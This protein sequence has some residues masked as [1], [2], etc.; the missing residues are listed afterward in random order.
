MNREQQLVSECARLWAPP[1]KQK[2]SEWAEQNFVLS[3][4]YSAHSGPLKLY[5]FQRE[6]L[7][8]FTDPYVRQLVCDTSTQMIKTLLQQIAIAYVIA[9]APGP[10]LAAQPT[11]TDAETFSKERLAPMIR[12]MA[13][14][15]DR[16]APERKTSKANTT[17]HKVFPGGSLSLI[18]AQTPGDFARRSIRY[19]FADERDKW[20]TNVGKEGD[21]FSLGVK[22]TATF[23]SLAKIIQTC[24]PTIE[25]QSQIAAAYSD[26][27]QRKFWV[28]CPE[29]GELQI[30][31]WE[32]VKFDV[33]NPMGTARYECHQCKRGISDVERWDRCESGVW[34]PDAHFA[35]TAGFWIS[36]LYSP[37]KRLGELATDFLAKKN[38]PAELQ[39]F[40]NT[41][42]AETWKEQGDAPDWEKLMART[43]PRDGE[44]GYR[45]GEVPPGVLFLTSGVD[46]QKT[47][48]QGHVWGWGRNR[49]RW[50][51]DRFILEGDPYRDLVWDALAYQ[52]N[53]T[54]RHPSGTDLSIV[55]MAVDSGYATQEVY[56]WARQQGSA[57]VMVIKGS[58]HGA[59][60]VSTPSQVDITI[61]GKKIKH[62]A[63]VYSVNVSMCKSEWYGLL[64]K[65]RPE[66]GEPYPPGWVHFA[67]DLDEEFF[68]Q[69]TAEQL[70]T[71]IVKGYRKSE[72]IKTRERNEDLD[73]AASYAR[74][75]ASVLGA[76][77]VHDSHWAI[78]PASAPVS[79]PPQPI[80]QQAPPPQSI[81][82]RDSRNDWFS[83]GRSW[84]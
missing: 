28:P 5:K 33:T 75:A 71:H 19:F 81:A 53:R 42:L 63:R 2:L 48:L 79:A 39:T 6:I 40:V 4:E 24:S 55:R 73:C 27:D 38:N 68:R 49:Q 83:G 74:A 20:P 15:R 26:S 31:R 35:G 25:G 3:S 59:A 51:I 78:L 14:L 10:I 67:T 23:R 37:W 46:V 47:W 18:G 54:Y 21:G 16:V 32:Q 29:C 64:G 9:R 1:P 69:I 22:R 62:G 72:W 36:E 34:R 45:L 43:I 44:V 77:R 66:A 82:E 65:D 12:D 30:L 84:F 7:D 61:G 57:R 13:C 41:S 70:V 58:D 56:R 8:A 17:L 76:D 80:P 52:L 50:I 11:A 60:L